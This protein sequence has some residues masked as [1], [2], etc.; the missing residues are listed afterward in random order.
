MA[1][2]QHLHGLLDDLLHDARNPLNAMAINVELLA[3]RLRRESAAPL[4]APH[5]KSLETLRTQ[6]TRMDGILKGFCSFLAPRPLEG[7]VDLAAVVRGAVE[8]LGHRFKSKRLNVQCELPSRLEI[9]HVAAAP[10]SD[11]VFLPLL[12]AVDR[13][14][15]GGRIEIAL[16]AQEQFAHLSLVDEGSGVVEPQEQTLRALEAVCRAQDGRLWVRQ[17]KV[18]LSLPLA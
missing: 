5:Q 8:V 16:R 6:I 13:S 9:R 1:R 18:E 12:W 10:V 4:P 14:P 3:E 11:L 15:S 17:G 7:P 2:A